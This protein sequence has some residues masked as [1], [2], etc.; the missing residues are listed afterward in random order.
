MQFCPHT[1]KPKTGSGPNYDNIFTSCNINFTERLM[2]ILN[3]TKPF[4]YH[5]FIAIT[6]ENFLHIRY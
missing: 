5:K 3:V 6:F 4:Q 2:M 1:Q